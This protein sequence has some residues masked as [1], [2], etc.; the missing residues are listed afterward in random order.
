MKCLLF[1]PT[2]VKVESNE[3]IHFEWDNMNLTT[4]INGSNIDNSAGGIMIQE[5]KTWI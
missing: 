4:S 3:V 1:D 2:E 5:V